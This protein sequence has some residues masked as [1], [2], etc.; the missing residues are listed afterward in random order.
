METTMAG[1]SKRELREV[2]SE[3]VRETMR[4]TLKGLGLDV[5]NPLEVQSD[6]QA[7]RDWRLLIK[8]AR[9]RFIIV[10]VGIVVAGAFAAIWAGI[11]SFLP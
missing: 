6:F 9:H 4:D 11:K 3:T 1:M 8:S 10:T 5:D 2:V 7:L